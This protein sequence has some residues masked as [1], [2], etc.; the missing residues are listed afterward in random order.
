L[1]PPRVQEAN[2]G[3]FVRHIR[4]CSLDLASIRHGEQCCLLATLLDQ[5]VNYPHGMGP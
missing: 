3:L 1:A 5:I 2:A 4:R